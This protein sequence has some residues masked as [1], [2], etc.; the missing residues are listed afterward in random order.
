MTR[1]A[2]DPIY[3]ST[4]LA[5]LIAVATVALIAGVTPPSENRAHRRLLIL[6][7]SIA[8]LAMLSTVFRPALVRTDNRPADATLVVAADTSRSMTLPDGDGNDRWKIGRA[9]V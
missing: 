1:F 2:L 9:H 4:W 6:L 5:L 8:A 3:G 7:R